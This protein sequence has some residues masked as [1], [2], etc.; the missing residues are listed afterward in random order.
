VGLDRS[1][2]E[3]ARKKNGIPWI[4]TNSA[5]C[6]RPPIPTERKVNPDAFATPGQVTRYIRSDT[7]LHLKFVL[8][9][10]PATPLGNVN[11]K[12]VDAIVVRCNDGI[13][14]ISLRVG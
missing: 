12:F 14:A 11:G 1:T 4:L 6:V 2:D 10:L 5:N 9:R 13:E 7:Q 8:A 3:R